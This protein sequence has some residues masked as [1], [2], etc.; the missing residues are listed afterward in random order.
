[1]AE[2]ERMKMKRSEDMGV[3]KQREGGN[4][5]DIG[6]KGEMPLYKSWMVPYHVPGLVASITKLGYSFPRQSPPRCT[7][8][9]A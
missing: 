8:R 5:V 3:S 6:G 4:S 2:Q 9:K 7:G 1:M